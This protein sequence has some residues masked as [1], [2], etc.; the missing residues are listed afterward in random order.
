MVRILGNINY[1]ARF[2]LLRSLYLIFP[3]KE[4]VYIIDSKIGCYFTL[5][6]QCLISHQEM[7][8]LFSLNT[9]GFGQEKAEEMTFWDYG[10][11]WSSSF[12]SVHFSLVESRVPAGESLSWNTTE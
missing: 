6:G 9:A 1:E 8:F 7:D 11:Q 10:A 3:K 12:K 4:N 5:V 2:H